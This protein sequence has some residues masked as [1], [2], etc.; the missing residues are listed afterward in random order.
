MAANKK[1]I[2]KTSDWITVG[3]NYHLT[4]VD[5]PDVPNMAK[6]LNEERISSQSFTIPHPYLR[7]DAEHFI[8][9]TLAFE[10]RE[11]MQSFWAIRASSGDLI[12]GIGLLF[13]EGV[14][15]HSSDFGYWLA[16]PFWNQGIMTQVIR[17]FTRHVFGKNLLQRLYAKVFAGNRASCRVLEKSGFRM[18]RL[19]K[20][21]FQ[22]GSRDIDAIVYEMNN[23]MYTAQ[24]QQ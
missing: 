19:E 4:V 11:G 20:A 8:E 1:T 21:A 17:A 22:K 15:A 16:V 6:Y 13:S 12:G 23:E 7:S 24:N 2:S 18:I 3:Q 5:Y 9:Q 10:A 14:D